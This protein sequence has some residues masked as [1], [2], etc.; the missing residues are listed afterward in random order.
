MDTTRDLIN[1]NETKA[2]VNFAIPMIIGNIFQQ[3]YNVA[4]TVIVGKFIGSNALAAVGSSFSVMVLLTSIIIGFCMGSSVVFSLI[5]GAKEIDKLKNCFFTAFIFIGIVTVIIN[6]CSIIFID[7]ILTFI[8]IPEEIFMDAKIY[9]QI[10]IF[11][12]T[13]ALLCGASAIR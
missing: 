6:V 9:L 7:E 11:I 12:I 5:Y 4:D 10:N 3:L 13:S 8:N 2:M 1:G